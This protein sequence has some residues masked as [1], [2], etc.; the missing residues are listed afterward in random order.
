MS[1]LQGWW[2][3]A[4]PAA[5]YA[6]FTTDQGPLAKVVPQAWLG[7]FK[8]ED[9]KKLLRAYQTDFEIYDQRSQDPQN[10]QVDLYI[11]MK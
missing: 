8:L 11:G 1:H 6:V 3:G 5:T 4:F 10:A 7:V 2:P 9:E